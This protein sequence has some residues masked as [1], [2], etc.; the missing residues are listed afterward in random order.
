[1][2]DQQADVVIT[3]TQFGASQGNGKVEIGRWPTYHDDDKEE[4]IVDTWTDTAITL[5]SVDA[6][7]WLDLLPFTFYV[8][9]TPGS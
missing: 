2:T 6:T 8:W 9:V 3:G 1:V 5:T 4:Q 7:T